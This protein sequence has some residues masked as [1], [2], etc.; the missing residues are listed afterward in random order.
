[1]MTMATSGSRRRLLASIASVGV[2]IGIGLL[3]GC[4]GDRA[5]EG[6]DGE[7]TAAEGEA[8]TRTTELGPV[9]ATVSLAPKEPAL[10]DPLTLTLEVE[11][12]PGVQVEMPSFGEALGRFQ[13]VQFVPRQSTKGEKGDEQDGEKIVY[14][15]TYTLQ[16]PMSG[17]QRIP[18]L[19]IELVD[20]R[21][22]Q[23]QNDDDDGM[24]RTQELLTDELAIEVASVLPEGEVAAALR[25]ARESLAPPS[26]RALYLAVALALLALTGVGAFLGF[27]SWRRRARQ[28]AR[29]SAYDVAMTRLAALERRGL[30]GSDNADA[31]YVDLSAIV[32]RYLEDRYGLRAPELTT[33]EFL[34]EAQRSGQLTNSHRDIL[35]GFLARCDRVKFARYEPQDAESQEALDAARLFLQETQPQQ[36]HQSH[37]NQEARPQSAPPNQNAT[38]S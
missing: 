6:Q 15:Q 16:A 17:H 25:P 7:P 10:G 9:R 8:I 30:P 5:P 26:D 14:A 35:S 21:P 32:R 18:P 4:G 23:A 29:I 33:E 1:M 37:Q 13:I 24:A 28:Q 12:E 22:G 38:M 11:A 31:W 2:C 20:E 3:A 34:I 36:S 19:R 27:R